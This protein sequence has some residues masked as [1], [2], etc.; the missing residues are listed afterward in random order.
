MSVD[1]T[2]YSVDKSIAATLRISADTS[3]PTEDIRAATAI[4]FII[5]CFSYDT[6]GIERFS[7]FCA[8]LNPSGGGKDISQWTF[9]A[10]PLGNDDW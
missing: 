5:G 6:L 1:T 9:S 2:K 3:L 7:S 4:Y 8:F 10:C